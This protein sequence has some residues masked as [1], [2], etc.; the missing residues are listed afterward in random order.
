MVA[1]VV[2]VAMAASA[3]IGDLRMIDRI[4][5]RDF[6]GL[7]RIFCRHCDL[8]EKRRTT[9]GRALRQ[10]IAIEDTLVGREIQNESAFRFELLKF[11]QF[12]RQAFNVTKTICCKD[13]CQ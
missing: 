2:V 3:Q 6:W 7:E 8:D 10:S 5:Q 12:D 11:F 13:S 4:Q 9:I 1:F